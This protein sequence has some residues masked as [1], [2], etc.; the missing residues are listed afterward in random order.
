MENISQERA[1]ELFHQFSDYIFKTAYMLTHSQVLADDITQESFIRVFRHYHTYDEAKPIK[2]WIYKIVVNTFRELK[3]K[4]KWLIFSDSLPE[5]KG[6]DSLPFENSLIKKETEKVLS[7]AVNKL[8]NKYKEVVILYYFND[9][10]LKEM[11]EVLSI[12]LGTCKSRL[13]YAIKKLNQTCQQDV[14]LI[15]GHSYES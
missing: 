12:P 7:E 5:D 6:N 2:P 10:S 4:Q 11:A 15:G 8:P 3:R 1:E 13:H 14:L 9:F